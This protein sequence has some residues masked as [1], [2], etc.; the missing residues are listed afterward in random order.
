MKNN[1]DYF[2]IHP[3]SK[4]ANIIPNDNSILANWSITSQI[5]VSEKKNWLFFIH[6]NPKVV[7]HSESGYIYS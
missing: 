1:Y 5:R 3:N 6:P 4:Y 7:D 2:F